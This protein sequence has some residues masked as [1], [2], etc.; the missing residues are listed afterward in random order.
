LTITDDH[1]QHR[2]DAPTPSP[3]GDAADCVHAWRALAPAVAGRAR[4]RVSRDGGRSYPAG[5]E[6][7]LTAELPDRPA[8]VMLFGHDGG[9]RCLA[10]D[11]DASRGG[12]A[13]VA[14]DAA[15]L[16][17]LVAACGGRSFADVSPNGGRHVYVLWSRPRP[18]G[19]L[20]PLMRAL[21]GLYPS[22]DPTPM[23]NPTAGC[24]RP[25]G[26][27][28]RS[29]G[30]QQL[31]TPLPQ[32]LA[33]VATPC[34]PE[35]WN[36][37]LDR[38]SPTPDEPEQAARTPA[39]VDHDRTPRTVSGGARLSDRMERIARTGVWEGDRYRS[40]SEARQAVITAAAAAGWSLPDIAARIETGRWPGLA[41]LYARYS[42]RAR[43][44][45]LGRDLRKAHAH[46]GQ[47]DCGRNSDTRD[48]THRGG[49]GS[50]VGEQLP[51]S[52]RAREFRWVRAWWNAVHTTETTRWTDRA[53]IS[54][55]LVLRALGA[56]AQRRGTRV[57][58]VGVRGLALACGLD[59]STVSVV[60]R[61]LREEDDPVVELLEEARGERADRYTLRIPDAGLHAAAWRRWRPGR[62]EAIHPVFRA[63]GPTAALVHE[64]LTGQPIR[65]GDIVRRAVLA[66]RT[67]T[68]ALRVLAE[69]GLAER[70]PRTGWRRGPV[71]PDRIART[72]GADLAHE[73]LI[74]RYRTE[75]AGWRELLDRLGRRIP[76]RRVP[77]SPDRLAWPAVLATP[78]PADAADNDYDSALAATGPPHTDPFEA[79]VELLRRELGAN[80]A[81][82]TGRPVRPDRF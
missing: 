55:R 65:R 45:A 39:P 12:P 49:I 9:A 6:R 42:A 79:A 35:V 15:S 44:A 60:L 62:I 52:G 68:A 71:H 54:K 51:E 28:H 19:E 64:T 8:A 50:G 66:P 18:I 21:C 14:V 23:L 81:S 57:L 10:A 59:H 2:L 53:G 40:P 72:L 75:R 67:V 34:G 4:V 30:R 36:A 77:N 22:L 32:A 37:L 56:M 46:L 74:S 31:T 7:D 58:E 80:I 43:R 63:L 82:R 24:I 26:A 41:A 48:N 69:H 70:D 73:N 1:R 27:R 33:A 11:F 13:Q 38:L 20:Q 29:G 47:G 5:C 76:G 61:A 16:A 78:P 25:P 3:R 17:A